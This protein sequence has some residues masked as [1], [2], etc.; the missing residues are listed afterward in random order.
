MGRQ[1]PGSLFRKGGEKGDPLAPAPKGEGVEGGGGKAHFHAGAL[2]ELGG[3]R[4]FHPHTV[5][6]GGK[7]SMSW[8]PLTT[9]LREE[10]GGASML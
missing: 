4:K 6:G 7:G 2:L 5:G 9:M 10:K 3:K 8:R 1:W